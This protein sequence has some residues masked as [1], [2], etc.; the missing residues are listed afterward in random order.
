M[1]NPVWSLTNTT[2]DNRGTRVNPA[3]NTVTSA[4]PQGWTQI[5]NYALFGVGPNPNYQYRINQGKVEY[6][7]N[8]NQYSNL[9][10][11]ADSLSGTQS[12]QVIQSAINSLKRN[13][14]ASLSQRTQEITPSQPA[15]AQ[16][17]Q[18][19]TGPNAGPAAE[20]LSPTTIPEG[21]FNSGQFVS[22]KYPLTIENGQDRV[23]ITQ[24]QYKRSQ[25][26]QT[27]TQLRNLKKL[28]GT[29]T[30]PM[31]NDLSE[32]NSVGWGEDSLSNAAA[33]L[34]PGLSGL[35]VSIAGGNFGTAAADVSK[36]AEA[37]QNKGLSTRIQQSLQV[38][39][40]ASIL[41][42]ANVNVNPEA[43]ISRVTSAAI[44]PNLELLFSGPKLR[45]FSLAYKMVARSKEE[46]TEIRKILRFFKKGMAPQ[47][48]QSQE[49]SFFLGAPN[50]FRID[51]K[52]GSSDNNLK[53]IG[54]FKT[55]A[56]VAFSANYT[57]DGFYAAFDDPNVGSQPIAV[58]MQMGFTELTPVFNDEYDDNAMDDVGPNSFT[59]DYNVL[60]LSGTTTR[61]PAPTPPPGS[62]TP[63][64]TVVPGVGVVPG[65]GLGVVPPG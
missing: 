48:T 29:V 25:V 23:V 26:V 49:F 46:A 1:A 34:M 18:G 59:K 54:Q 47:R 45:Q 9:Q 32:V 36:L 33:L 3:L 64:R 4:N 50:V 35:A 24:F 19:G 22:A 2:I 11:Y 13:I 27:E 10:Q 51:F 63:A 21:T 42:K 40:A 39:A 57:P 5:A 16:G 12:T 62:Q 17:A 55:C 14:T 65:A 60:N 43:Y 38:N 30:L 53:S 61:P 58:T 28:N 15:P 31:P 6:K 7:I 52:S 37:I 44:N 20:A 8:G 56:L 41:K